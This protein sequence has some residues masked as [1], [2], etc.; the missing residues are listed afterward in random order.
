[1]TNGL[2][3]LSFPTRR[4]ALRVSRDVQVTPKLPSILFSEHSVKHCNYSHKMEAKA[5]LLPIWTLAS[6]LG[7]IKH[8]EEET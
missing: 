1:M 4:L 3:S 2:Q 7:V 5:K 8:A 6:Q